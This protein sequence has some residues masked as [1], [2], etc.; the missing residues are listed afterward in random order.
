MIAQTF[1]S[2]NG[3]HTE[4]SGIIFATA[5]VFLGRHN[6]HLGSEATLYVNIER[7]EPPL[8]GCKTMMLS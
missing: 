7:N 4:T 1:G 8:K 5:W 6:I 2:F 3:L